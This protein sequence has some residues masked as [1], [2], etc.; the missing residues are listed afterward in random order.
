MQI[1]TYIKFIY[2]INHNW[3]K[4]NKFKFIININRE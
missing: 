3:K 2:K 1:L 4:I